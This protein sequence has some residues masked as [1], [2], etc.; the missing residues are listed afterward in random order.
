MDEDAGFAR[1]ANRPKARPPRQ[2]LSGEIRLSKGLE[3]GTGTAENLTSS[4]SRPSSSIVS[5]RRNF[6]SFLAEAS[7]KNFDRVCT[8]WLHVSTRP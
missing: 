6:F 7:D 2:P 8:A 5:S 3:I 1:E 4:F